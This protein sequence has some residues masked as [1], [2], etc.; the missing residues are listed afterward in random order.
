MR[1]NK[2]QYRKLKNIEGKALNHKKWLTNLTDIG[3]CKAKTILTATLEVS[4][5]LFVLSVFPY[6]FHPTLVNS[7]I[8]VK[9]KVSTLHFLNVFIV[10]PL[11][12][13]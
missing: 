3:F 6:V 5:H 11:L 9:S 1:G 7:L 12:C 10:L 8:T 13:S 2:F 4:H